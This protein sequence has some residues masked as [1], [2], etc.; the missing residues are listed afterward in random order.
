MEYVD[1][2]KYL[3]ITQLHISKSSILRFS[4]ITY[5]FRRTFLK[6]SNALNTVSY[7]RIARHS[8][9]FKLIRQM[10]HTFKTILKFDIMAWWTITFPPCAWF[11]RILSSENVSPGSLQFL[12]H[13]QDVIHSIFHLNDPS[14]GQSN[15]MVIILDLLG[16]QHLLSKHIPQKVGL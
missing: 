5:I 8:Y 9:C 6:A 14:F 1:G 3:C 15:W 13:T 7:L 10:C 2:N 12:W 16:T 4:Y 11:H